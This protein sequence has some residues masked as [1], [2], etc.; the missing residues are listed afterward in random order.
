MDIGALSTT[1]GIHVKISGF[2][3]KLSKS[4]RYAIYYELGETVK[5]RAVLECGRD[6]RWIQRQL[7]KRSGV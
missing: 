7:W 2:H 3:R 5:V 1:A 6:P 4:F